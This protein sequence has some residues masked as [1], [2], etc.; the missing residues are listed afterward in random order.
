MTRNSL[1]VSMAAVVGLV[2]VPAIASAQV[3]AGFPTAPT[4]SSLALSSAFPQNADQFGAEGSINL[5]GPAAVFAGYQR[6]TATAEGVGHA[7]TFTAGGALEVSE[8]YVGPWAMGLSACP[9][10]S[11]SLTRMDDAEM[12]RVPLGVGF[13]TRIEAGRQGTLELMPYV[14]PQ[15]V[16]TRASFSEAHGTGILNPIFGSNATIQDREHT[17]FAVRTGVMMG[18]GRFFVGGEFNNVFND[19]TAGVFGV[20]AGVRF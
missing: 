4:Q 16:W 18:A 13:G 17:D 1:F 6:T 8:R 10:A 9:V 7:N 3:C 12:W 2:T 19:E 5:A 11:V 20:K 15:I 14:V